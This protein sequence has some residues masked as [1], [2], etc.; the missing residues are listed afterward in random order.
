MYCVW[1]KDTIWSYFSHLNG[2][3]VLPPPYKSVLCVSLFENS[4]SVFENWCPLLVFPA[5]E[6]TLS[7]L[8]AAWKLLTCKHI[9]S[10]SHSSW[11]IY[12]G[13]RERDAE[14]DRER[15]RKRE[16]K[17]QQH[18]L[19]NNIQKKNTSKSAMHEQ[20]I[21]EG[22]LN[23]SYWQ[24]MNPNCLLCILKR[25]LCNHLCHQYW[26]YIHWNHYTKVL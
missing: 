24:I 17:W 14:R 16:N 12:S 2:M 8:Y 15:D 19:F 25:K 6:V 13:K 3:N 5:R 4:C 21:Q 20:N 23:T 9:L 18:L 7:F 26:Q 1:C 22:T 10:P 11:F